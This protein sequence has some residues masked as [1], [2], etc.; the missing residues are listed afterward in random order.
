MRA[1]RDTRAVPLFE[2]RLPLNDP[3][4]MPAPPVRNGLGPI[5]A[6]VG[7][8]WAKRAVADK[9]ETANLELVAFLL[10]NVGEIR[11]LALEAERLLEAIEKFFPSGMN[12]LNDH[13]P[14]D[15]EVPLLAQMGEL[16]ALKDAISRAQEIVPRGV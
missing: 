3:A 10:N 2:T 9:R 8:K 5:I 13:L 15:I 12:V 6:R 16:R 11:E 14:D 4:D 7:S 1:L